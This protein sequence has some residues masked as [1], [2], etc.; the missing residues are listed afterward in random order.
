MGCTGC[1]VTDCTHGCLPTGGVCALVRVTDHTFI[2]TA[3]NGTG[4]RVKRSV[5]KVQPHDS[6]WGTDV[7]NDHKLWTVGQKV[8]LSS[9]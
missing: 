9:H 1:V 6:V 2:V 4:E 5:V 7:P 8:L 3:V